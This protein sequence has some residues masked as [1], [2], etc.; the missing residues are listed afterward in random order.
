L[1][2]A[3]LRPGP[4]ALSAAV[5]VTLLALLGPAVWSYFAWRALQRGPAAG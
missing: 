5:V 1:P 4:R 2:R 3:L